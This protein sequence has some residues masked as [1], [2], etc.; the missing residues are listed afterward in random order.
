VG[1]G[2]GVQG[3]DRVTCRSS[4]QPAPYPIPDPP[5]PAPRPIPLA[6]R[7]PA[8]DH[9]LHDGPDVVAVVS[10]P[11]EEGV[12][13]SALRLGCQLAERGGP[14]ASQ[15]LEDRTGIDCFVRKH[16]T[17]RAIGDGPVH[18]ATGEVQAHATRRGAS[19]DNLCPRQLSGIGGVIQQTDRSQPSDRCLDL[20]RWPSSLHEPSPKLVGRVRTG[21]QHG[22]RAV[23][24]RAAYS[25]RSR[26]TRANGTPSWAAAHWLNA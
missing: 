13:A 21:A 15:S 18:S 6:T 20:C 7:L 19:A 9:D 24:G 23:V 14:L 3:T 16:F 2:Y 22:E 12:E 4:E 25:G 1:T 8:P 5:T 10:A 11:S 17:D 26:P